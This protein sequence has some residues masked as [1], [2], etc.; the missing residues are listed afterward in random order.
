MPSERA[1]TA[2]KARPI[3]VVIRIARTTGEPRV[4]AEVQLLRLGLC[5]HALER[6]AGD[7]VER[8]LRER[9]RAAV[10]REE[11]EARRRDPDQEGL[12]EDEVH[13]VVVEDERPEGG[14]DESPDGDAALDERLQLGVILSWKRPGAG[15]RARAPGG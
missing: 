4:P 6:E 8:H 7:A 11:D 14:E 9:D 10:G 13:P 1:A 12:G 15:R 2:P 3:A 5:D